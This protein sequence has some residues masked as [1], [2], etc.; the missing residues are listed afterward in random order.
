MMIQNPLPTLNPLYRMYLVKQA[1]GVSDST[2]YRKIQKRLFTS[3][4]KIGGQKVAWPA[5]EVQAI[6]NA[7]I[8]GKSEDE[9]EKLVFDL[10]AKRVAVQ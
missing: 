9:I 1:M 4:I 2:I 3:P 7:Q 8:A 10:E 5:N 6:I